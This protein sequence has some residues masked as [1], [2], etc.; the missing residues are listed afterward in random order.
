MKP[1]A[2]INSPDSSKTA[3]QCE[4]PQKGQPVSRTS[5][6][7]TP[8]RQAGARKSNRRN[9]KQELRSRIEELKV[10][11]REKERLVAALTERLEQ[12]A[13][14]LDRIRRTGADRALRLPATGG[15][16]SELVDSQKS[17]LQKLEHAIEQW[18]DLQA[19]TALG[20]L[21][22]Q[23]SELRD[24]V[25]GNMK[26]ARP[27]TA[28]T[29]LESLKRKSADSPADA[30]RSG[31]TEN[32]WESLK[33]EILA[34]D[35]RRHG[36]Q[37]DEDD[38]PAAPIESQR[39]TP[40]PENPS[41]DKTQTAQADGSGLAERDVEETESSADGVP[42]PI[43]ASETD[44]DRLREA[45][46]MRDAYI[47]SLL[48]KLKTIPTASLPVDWEMLQ[49]VPDELRSRLQDLEV[50]LREKIRF[51]EVDLSLERARL[52]REEAALN[53]REIRL[54]GRAKQLGLKLDDGDT[55]EKTN[56]DD[57]PRRKNWLSF[58]LRG[59]AN[60]GSESDT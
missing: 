30:A 26:E 47:S 11:L 22:V 52:A 34:R 28:P 44:P 49:E 24:L 54:E 38:L 27:S 13:E 18:E 33:A 55:D 32:R 17:L 9:D 3:V 21:E 40:D 51:A 20:R 2:A 46:E 1:D 23:V 43:D 36:G 8:S 10:Q 29:K 39:E 53:Q 41:A 6:T 14:Q 19:A 31:A 45:I 42:E 50:Q 16:P 15:L 25:S 60:D 4:S 7:R 5:E 35:V 56:G 57:G 58:L 37:A 12:A 48:K 59:A